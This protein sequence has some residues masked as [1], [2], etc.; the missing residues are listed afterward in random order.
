MLRRGLPCALGSYVVN[1]CLVPDWWQSQYRDDVHRHAK[2]IL[3]RATQAA[4]AARGSEVADHSTHPLTA[5]ASTRPDTHHLDEPDTLTGTSS[6][7]STIAL[8]D[9]RD[10]DV[11]AAVTPFDADG[12]ASCAGKSVASEAKL[13]LDAANALVATFVHRHDEESLG[14]AV[15]Y[16][17]ETLQQPL[18]SFHYHALLRSFSHNLDHASAVQLLEVM[19]TRDAAMVSLETYAR[20]VDAVHCL[21]PSD[22]WERILAICDVA[23][24]TFRTLVRTIPATDACGDTSAGGGEWETMR[25]LMR[26]MAPSKPSVPHPLQSGSADAHEHDGVQDKSLCAGATTR[27]DDTR[28]AHD[29]GES[30]CPVDAV[31]NSKTIASSQS[32]A[33]HTNQTIHSSS[34]SSSSSNTTATSGRHPVGGD[35]SASP[36]VLRSAPVL[37]SL[38]HHIACRVDSGGPVAALLVALWIRCLGVPLS[39]WDCAFV[40]LS[41]LSQPDMFPLV[42]ALMS[43]FADCPRGWCDRRRCCSVSCVADEI[44]RST[45]RARRRR[46][47]IHGSGTARCPA[48]RDRPTGQIHTRTS[49][50]VEWG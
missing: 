2:E 7:N 16:I 40:I 28:V 13:S 18:N 14:E 15:Q 8:D 9:L 4:C 22:V 19:T 17:R 35:A 41:L 27:H 32:D 34:S 6:S 50:W 39:E 5:H 46:R 29:S 24:R 3:K 25:R 20:V 33:T 11:C 23:Q 44:Q 43:S 47:R 38:L 31:T 26:V 37:T 48:Q 45:T 1:Q 21:A 42:R 30:V 10:E 12:D 49:G 36:V